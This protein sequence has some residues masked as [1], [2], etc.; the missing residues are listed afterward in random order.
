MRI[1]ARRARK[2]PRRQQETRHREQRRATR[3]TS[4]ATQQ[5]AHQNNQQGTHQRRNRA[6]MYSPNYRR[7][8]NDGGPQA[9]TQA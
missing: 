2:K 5:E 8:A 6:I 7:S 9:T 1:N 3:E 4:R